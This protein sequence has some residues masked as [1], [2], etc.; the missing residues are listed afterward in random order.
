MEK[1]AK[2]KTMLVREHIHKKIKILAHE[3]GMSM[4]AYIA[5]LVADKEPKTKPHERKK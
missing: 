3:A 5:H 1:K 4:A 2:L